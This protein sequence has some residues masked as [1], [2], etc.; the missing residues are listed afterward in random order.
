LPSTTGGLRY[1]VDTDD[2]N[3]PQDIANLASDLDTKVVHRFGTLAALQA[4][5]PSP[6][7]GQVAWVTAMGL[8][9]YNGFEWR[10]PS[11]LVK[12]TSSSTQYNS[13]TPNPPG[14]TEQRITGEINMSGARHLSGRG[15]E[16]GFDGRA[17]A[18][19]TTALTTLYIRVST[20]S[21]VTT[22]NSKVV[23]AH[24]F[25]SPN[26]GVNAAT[27]KF[28]GQYAV[29]ATNLY[30]IA[31]FGK[32]SSGNFAVGEDDR[33]RYELTLRET[34]PSVPGLVTVT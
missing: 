13:D 31:L 8:V 34:G 9:A 24:E 28:R 4:A 14:T 17:W 16:I 19:T 30:N 25:Y 10:G 3:V 7:V 1:P 23:A 29:N 18:G 32:V 12:V 22:G 2:F 33:G 11:G 26:T 21:P 20:Q 27:V 5:Y 6:Q 15:Y